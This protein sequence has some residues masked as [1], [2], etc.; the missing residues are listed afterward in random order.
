MW[1]H[2]TDTETVVDEDLL[3]SSWIAGLLMPPRAGSVSSGGQS[4]IGKQEE[5]N[6]KSVLKGKFH[7]GED[8]N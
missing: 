7:F 2:C 5:K 3:S 6:K 8:M 1:E 4:W